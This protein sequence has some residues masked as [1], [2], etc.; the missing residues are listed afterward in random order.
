MDDNSSSETN[1]SEEFRKLGQNIQDIVHAAINSEQRE[2]ACHELEEGLSE[3]TSSLTRAVDDFKSSQTGQQLKED[4][5]D[6]KQQVATGEAQAKVQ[7]DLSGA[8]HSI[9]EELSKAAGNWFTP[10]GGSSQK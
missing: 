5:E 6:I 10:S 2:K 1:V 7:K 4:L 3:L 9:N 8:L